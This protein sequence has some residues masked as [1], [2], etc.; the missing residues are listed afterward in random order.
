MYDAGKI[1]TGIFIFLALFLS[2]FWYGWT[3]G[4]GQPPELVLS[5]EAKSA[6]KCVESLEFMKS[7]HMDL[8]NNWRNSV[9]R[10]GNREYT[11]QDGTTYN[12][13]LG[14]TCLK[15]HTNEAEFC[16]RCHNF[17]AVAPKCFDCHVNPA[18]PGDFQP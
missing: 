13:S 18:H 12:M 7:N 8:L 9:V 4:K 15:C 10:D 14:N 5:A 3:F 16:D 2:P 11:A 17:E 6:G 1:L